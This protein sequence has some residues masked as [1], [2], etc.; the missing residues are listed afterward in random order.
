[1]SAVRGGMTDVEL[2]MAADRLGRAADDLRQTGKTRAI[3]PETARAIAV[4]RTYAETAQLWADLAR[5][6]AVTGL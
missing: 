2:A 5:R 1:M 4:A 3:G 6:L